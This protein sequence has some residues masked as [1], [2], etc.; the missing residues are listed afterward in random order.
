MQVPRRHRYMRLAVVLSILGSALCLSTA[1]ASAKVVVDAPAARKIK[2]KSDCIRYLLPQPIRDGAVE[3]DVTGLDSTS[4]SWAGGALVSMI[5]ASAGGDVARNPW[6]FQWS[7]G[8]EHGSMSYVMREAGIKQFDSSSHGVSD[9]WLPGNTHHF[10]AAWRDG[11][12]RFWVD[13]EDFTDWDHVYAV[14]YAPEKHEILL[15]GS[16]VDAIVGA[17]F[18]NIKIYDNGSPKES[19]SAVTAAAP[20]SAC[21]FEEYEISLLTDKAYANPYLDVTLSATFKGPERTIRVNGFWDGGRLFKIRMLPTEP[22]D[23]TWTVS[24]NDSRLNGKSGSFKCIDSNDRGWVVVSKKHPHG[25]EWSGSGQ[26]FFLLGDT[27]W[28][29]WYN[30]RFSDGTFQKVVDARAAQRFN[31]IH[32]VVHDIAQ[33]E[34]GP[35]YASQLPNGKYDCDALNPGFFQWLDKKVAY[36][37]QRGMVAALFLAWGNE[38]YQ[39]Y[40]SSEQYK[41]YIKYMVARYASR[42]VFWLVVGEFEEAGE[43]DTMWV[44]YMDMVRENDPYV[45]PISMHTVNTTDRFGESASHTFVSHQRKGTPE[46]LRGL[47]ESSRRFGKPV[48][49]LEYGYESTSNAHRAFQDADQMRMDHYAITLAGGYGVFGNSVPGFNTF[50]RVSGFNPDAVYSTAARQM[51]V[52]YDFFTGLDFQRLEPAQQLVDSGICAR[53]P[54]EDYIVQILSVGSVTVD[55]GEAAGEFQVDWF[56]PKTGRRIPSGTTSG[57]DKRTFTSPSTPSEQFVS[58]WILHIH[59]GERTVEDQSLRNLLGGD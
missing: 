30:V 42:N 19:S 33:N 9:G 17:A 22:G 11:I 16:G 54:N 59:K 45:H 2:S 25:F 50:H 26:P 15:G 53:I 39:D 38:G 51:G 31:Y 7:L 10:R 18:S 49:N 3:F 14:A 55:L 57:G 47:I 56:D 44:S 43:P 52:M 8:K 12:M 6:R 4:A 20:S 5:D 41:R 40:A 35:I 24:S 46:Y 36:M 27:M 1:L 29:L 23:W 21:K 32:G 48:V 13:G 58:D 37:T 34:G 28:H